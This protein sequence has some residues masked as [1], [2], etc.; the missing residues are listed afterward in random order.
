MFLLKNIWSSLKDEQE[1]TFQ[2][3]DES[4]ISNVSLYHNLTMAQDY[5][6]LLSLTSL[7]D[8]SER[9][10]TLEK[11]MDLLSLFNY[12]PNTTRHLI[13]LFKEVMMFQTIFLRY[14]K[15]FSVMKQY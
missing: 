7:G 1:L 15:I 13:Q 14:L 8:F 5:N 3:N 9:K 12:N 11:R 10:F 2:D 4:H 6:S